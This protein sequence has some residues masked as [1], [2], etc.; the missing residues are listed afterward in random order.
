MQHDT[1]QSHVA[2]E[3]SSSPTHAA[4]RGLLASQNVGATEDEVDRSRD[5]VTP[6]VTDMGLDERNRDRP[7]LPDWGRGG[8]T[9]DD[10]ARPGPAGRTTPHGTL[11]SGQAIGQG[12]PRG[13][14]G[15]GARS[16]SGAGMLNQEAAGGMAGTGPLGGA[17][18]RGD[19]ADALAWR[20]ALGISAPSSPGSRDI[21]LGIGE[22][23]TGDPARTDMLNKSD[24]SRSDAL[25]HDGGPSAGPGAATPEQRDED[26]AGG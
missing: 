26:P 24:V 1:D 19:T 2:D 3:T 11:S 5:A 7:D 4:E 9:G 14:D 20:R 15:S 12:D 6:E 18:A 17:P 13:P 21:H 10:D 8:T 22:S 23:S 25:A 16:E